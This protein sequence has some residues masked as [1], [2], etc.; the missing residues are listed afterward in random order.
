[1]PM[2]NAPN[3]QKKIVF[4]ASLAESLIN[5]RLHLIKEFLA[6]NYSVVT[7]APEDEKVAHTLSQLG[8]KF[9]ALPLERNGNN[10]FNDLLILKQLFILLRRERPDLVFTY[11]I[12]PVIYG[13]LAAK[14]SRVPS[15][16]AMLTGTGYVFANNN[17]KSQIIGFIAR[18]LFRFSLR[19]NKKLFFQ[20]P[21]NVVEFRS[22]KLIRK[23]QP[24]AIINGSGVDINHFEYADPP[25]K[26]SFL[27]IARLLLDKG[28]REYVAAAKVIKQKYPDITFKLVGWIDTNPNSISEAELNEWISSGVIHYLGKLSDVRAVIQDSAVYV[29]P[30]YGEGTPRTVL[31]AMAIGR[32]II[33]TDVPG[34]R[35]TVTHGENGLLVNV[36]E[37]ESLA[38][39]MEYFILHPYAIHEMGQKSREK[40]VKKYDVNKV[41]KSMLEEMNIFDSLP[42]V[43]C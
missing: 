23:Q 10:P 24:V 17:L 38:K 20:N 27:M 34:C 40:A 26:L 6:R 33:T 3:S 19:F 9:I 35:E 12:K 5:F 22:H 4:I 39:A 36:K 7:I 28:V 11:T 21:D 43:V 1:M 18:S 8:V 42:G 2:K 41:N 16:Y 32:P 14:L 30:S 13:T 29:L 31:E 37:V 15:I 25:E